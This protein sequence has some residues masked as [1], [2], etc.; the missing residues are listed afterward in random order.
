MLGMCQLWLP[1]TLRA[2][3]LTKEETETSERTGRW[4]KAAE[5]C[6]FEPESDSKAWADSPGQLALRDRASPASAI[7]HPPDP[8][9]F[10]RVSRRLG[11]RQACEAP[12]HLVPILHD[13]AGVGVGFHH[14]VLLVEGLLWSNPPAKMKTFSSPLTS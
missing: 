5:L 4:P 3:A 7:P 13:V 6:E 8:G 10:R 1:I 14:L 12:T 9:S 11:C 2:R